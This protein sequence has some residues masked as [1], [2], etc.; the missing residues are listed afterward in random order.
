MLSSHRFPVFR[1]ILPSIFHLT[2]NKP[3]SS[4]QGAVLGHPTSFFWQDLTVKAAGFSPWHTPCRKNSVSLLHVCGKE[5]EQVGEHLVAEN[6][7]KSP[8]AAQT[9]SPRAHQR[10]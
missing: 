7:W 2:E 6:R 9:S 3:I 1:T 4:S 8:T 10:I 5:N